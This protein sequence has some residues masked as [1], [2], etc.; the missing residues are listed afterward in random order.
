VLLALP[1][2]DRACSGASATFTATAFGR[3][4]SG[5]LRSVP[6]HRTSR[7]SL[8]QLHRDTRP[9]PHLSDS[10]DPPRRAASGAQIR[11]NP[12]C[13]HL[14]TCDGFY[15]RKFN[16]PFRSKTSQ[17]CGISAFGGLAS[18]NIYS[19]FNQSQFLISERSQETEMSLDCRAV[20]LV[21]P[22]KMHFAVINSD[23][24]ARS[25]T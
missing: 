17:N 5:G 21:L 8:V 6:D 16:K 4:S 23:E 25:V 19:I 2:L 14:I 18:F 12:W 9:R 15:D 11:E 10:F 3:C 24:G 13:I 7:P 22:K 1:C 20:L